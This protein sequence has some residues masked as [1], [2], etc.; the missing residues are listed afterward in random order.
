[1]DTWKYNLYVED[2]ITWHWFMPNLMGEI[3]EPMIIYEDYGNIETIKIEQFSIE[4][5]L[6][7]ESKKI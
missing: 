2:F 5:D 1:M 6:E 3:E 7:I 4:S